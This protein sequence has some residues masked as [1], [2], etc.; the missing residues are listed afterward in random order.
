MHP[1]FINGTK[2][3]RRSKPRKLRRHVYGSSPL[4]I[5]IKLS[6]GKYVQWPT[7]HLMLLGVPIELGSKK[8]GRLSLELQTRARQLIRSTRIDWSDEIFWPEGFEPRRRVLSAAWTLPASPLAA[9]V[10]AFPTALL[11]I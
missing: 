8:A 5:K 11:N 3:G 6:G 9:Q 2:P 1:R 7:V 4:R 10:T